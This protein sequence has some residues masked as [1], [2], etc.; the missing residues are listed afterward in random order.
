MLHR[1][2]VK[3]EP[4]KNVEHIATKKVVKKYGSFFFLGLY[5]SLAFEH[6]EW[7]SFLGMNCANSDIGFSTTWIRINWDNDWVLDIG[8]LDFYREKI[9]WD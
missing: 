3:L 8:W 1:E 5:K 7:I 4:Q 2:L 6:Q 9:H